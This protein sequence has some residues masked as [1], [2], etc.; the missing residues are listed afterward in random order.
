MKKLVMYSDQIENRTKEVDDWVLKL[1]DKEN[2][3]VGYI[4]S[5]SDLTRKYFNQ[6]VEHYESMGIN[7]LLYFDLDEEYDE[8]KIN[9]LLSCDAIH[10]SGGNTFYFLQLLKK[11]NF[12]DIIRNYVLEGGVLIGIS[13]GSIMMSETIDAAAFGDEDNVR[14]ENK[15][16]LGL[17]DF[18]FMPHWER[19]QEYLQDLLDYSR[20]SNKV[21][22]ACNDGDGIIINGDKIEFIGDVQKIYDGKI[23]RI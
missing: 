7:D 21:I 10:L 3:K 18:E 6:K 16:A 23:S 1:I 13:A 4:P 17:V 2:P 14:D 5:C 20:K 22:Y 9:E 11:R 8:T 12:L 19:D 15:E